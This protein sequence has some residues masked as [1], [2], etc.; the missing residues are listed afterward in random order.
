MYKLIGINE[1][2]KETILNKIF[3]HET[4]FQNEEDQGIFHNQPHASLISSLIEFVVLTMQ[5]INSLHLTE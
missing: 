1:E 3:Y 2:K 4:Y 5:K